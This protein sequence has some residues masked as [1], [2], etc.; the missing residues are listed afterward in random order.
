M[1]FRTTLTGDAEGTLISMLHDRVRVMVRA[2][3]VAGL[4]LACPQVYGDPAGAE[5]VRD[6]FAGAEIS[7]QFW[8]GCKREE[9][10][11][12]VV[13]APGK[14]SAPSRWSSFHDPRSP[15]SDCCSAT[16]LVR[17]RT[18]TTSPGTMREPNC[19]RRTPFD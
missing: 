8:Y 14:T 4:I 3:P 7:R 12:D 5:T 1:I 6:D 15:R 18:A 17:T 9:N 16:S 13:K 10:Q 19:G 11:F 2:F